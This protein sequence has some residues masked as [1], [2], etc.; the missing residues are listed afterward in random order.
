[1]Q[2][3][4]AQGMLTEYQVIKFDMT[5][6]TEAQNL[7]LAELQIFGPPALQRYSMQG[8]HGRA[9]QGV[10]SLEHLASWLTQ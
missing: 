4:Q 7:Y 3:A 6:G 1:L 10:P 5:E 8:K 2:A 9:L